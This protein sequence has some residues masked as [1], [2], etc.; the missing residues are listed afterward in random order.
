MLRSS[1]EGNSNL[2]LG[3]GL[4]IL[5][6]LAGAGSPM[7]VEAIK[8]GTGIPASSAYRI[9]HSLVQRGWVTSAADGKY[10]PGPRFVGL[11]GALRLD[12]WVAGLAP[13]KM[14]QLAQATD[15]TVLLTVIT[16]HFA[17]CVA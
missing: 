2:T 12:Q 17:L 14:H 15:E 9:L 5:E 6:L 8:S 11:T 7:S 3:R 1:T 13:A 16:G 4:D 10:S